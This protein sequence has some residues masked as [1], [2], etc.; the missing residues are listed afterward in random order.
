[1][2]KYFITIQMLRGGLVAIKNKRTFATEQ[3][4]EK[5]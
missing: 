5:T 4:Q 2:C 1:M 3:K